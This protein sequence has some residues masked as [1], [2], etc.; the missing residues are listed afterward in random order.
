VVPHIS[1]C[2]YP[3]VCPQAPSF[4]WFHVAGLLSSE[5]A[6]AR[7]VW[8]GRVFQGRAAGLVCFSRP[9]SGLRLKLIYRI[10]VVV[11]N[12]G[13]FL[14]IRRFLSTTSSA[15]APYKRAHCPCMFR[16]EKMDNNSGRA[17]NRV[18]AQTVHVDMQMF[19]HREW[20]GNVRR[21]VGDKA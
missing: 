15:Y 3:W 16:L 12:G 14:W 9:S 4:A 2:G 18:F 8:T 1:S 21:F 20:R 11:V 6:L 10:V 7:A 5:P 17:V 13:P 19:I